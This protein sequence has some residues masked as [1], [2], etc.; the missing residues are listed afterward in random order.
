MTLFIVPFQ[1]VDNLFYNYCFGGRCILVK[2]SWQKDPWLRHGTIYFSF[3][4][5]PSHINFWTSHITHISCLISMPLFIKFTRYKVSTITPII[6]PQII[7]T[8]GHFI[9]LCP[10]LIGLNYVWCNIKPNL[11]WLTQKSYKGITIFFYTFFLFYKLF[12]ILTL[13]HII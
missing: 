3:L 13:G 9:Q 1:I 4:Q 11:Y 8:L 7:L 5:V 6:A 12:H 2:T 10:S